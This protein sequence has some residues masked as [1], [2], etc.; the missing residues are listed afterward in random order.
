MISMINRVKII[1]VQKLGGKVM[2]NLLK[3]LQN[4]VLT[5][6]PSALRKNLS[7]KKNLRVKTETKHA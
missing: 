6:V 7:T 1:Q 3:N 2:D 4:I 5:A